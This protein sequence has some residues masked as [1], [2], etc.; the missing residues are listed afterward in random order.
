MFLCFLLEGLV[1]VPTK[2]QG[3][4]VIWICNWPLQWY[5]VSRMYITVDV[6]RTD[7]Y[8]DIAGFTIIHY[9]RCTTHWLVQ[10]Y[11]VSRMYI[12]VDVQR[13]LQ[14]YYRLHECALPWMY[15]TH[16][17][18]QWY[19]RFHECVLPWMYTTHWL[20]Q[21]Y[22]TLYEYTIQST[23]IGSTGIGSTGI[24]LRELHV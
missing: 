24:K 5:E 20:L 18:L 16:W 17:L 13:T 23:G 2:K 19:Y 11:E 3:I 10:W 14:W 9:R 15:T 21:W 1:P 7:Y 22:F 8:S 12:T 6:Q 4:T